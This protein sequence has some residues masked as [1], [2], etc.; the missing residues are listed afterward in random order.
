MINWSIDYQLEEPP[1]KK[2]APCE[3][4]TVL[5]PS[6]PLKLYHLIH[7]LA[8]S[9][10]EATYYSDDPISLTLTGA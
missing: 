3:A 8:N 1:Q 6:K 5:S 7:I 10:L 9:L 4:A 2:S